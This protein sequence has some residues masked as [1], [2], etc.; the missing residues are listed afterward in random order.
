MPI[1]LALACA[2]H[3]PRAA[4]PADDPDHDGDGLSDFQEVHK[5]RT[6]PNRPD[7]D[8]D[9]IPDGDWDERREFTYTVRSVVQVMPPRPP[10]ERRA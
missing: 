5:Y 10:H 9:G 1:S 6:D 7:S 4:G 8:S 3:V 2:H